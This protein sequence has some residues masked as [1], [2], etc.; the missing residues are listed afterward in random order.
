MK[1]K[2]VTLC[3]CV[4]FTTLR[5]FAAPFQNLGFEDANTSAAVFVG[6]DLMASPADLVPGWQ[7][8]RDG[9]SLDLVG[10][11]QGSVP[12]FENSPGGPLIFDSNYEFRVGVDGPDPIEGRFTFRIHETGRGPSLAPSF[13]IVQRGDIPI[14]ARFLYY[15]YRHRPFEVTVNGVILTP[16][17]QNSLSRPTTVALDISSFAG[18]NVELRFRATHPFLPEFGPH[19][20]DSIAFVIPEASTVV[21][22]SFGLLALTARFWR[23]RNR[24]LGLNG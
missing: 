24:P 3:F 9:I 11:N 18:Q 12:F 20:L 1:A 16:P 10:Y 22:F 21:L 17:S 6:Q 23:R 4:V 15:T 7:V 8:F 5:S 14:D 2:L 13:S 19:D